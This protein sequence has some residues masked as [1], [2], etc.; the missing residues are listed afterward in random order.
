M[1]RLTVKLN[2]SDK[3]SRIFVSQCLTSSGQGF[4]SVWEK[5]FMCAAPRV[6]DKSMSVQH[7]NSFT[8]VEQLQWFL[9]ELV[10]C[11][12]KSAEVTKRIDSHW[13]WG[14]RPRVELRHNKEDD[15]GELC[16]GGHD[17][18]VLTGYMWMIIAMVKLAWH[19]NIRTRWMQTVAAGVQILSS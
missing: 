12:Y 9:T 6:N 5:I 14:S 15:K 13:L 7:W 16:D 10:V 1:S 2:F 4:F 3:L 18:H 8:L 19:K 11:S 17:D